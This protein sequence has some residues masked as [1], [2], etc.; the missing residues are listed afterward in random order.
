[1][2]KQLFLLTLSLALLASCSV[3][4]KHFKLEGRL[5]NLNQGELY[6]YSDE[7]GV[8]GIDTIKIGGGRFAYEIPCEK[9]ATIVLVF[10]NFSELPI[11]AEP[12]KTISIDGDASH[13]KELKVDGSK[14]NKLMSAFREQIASASPP[15]MSK[16]A[17]QQIEDHPDWPMG[18]YLVKKY[19]LTTPDPD[20]REA[21]RLIKTM[22]E[23][24][25]RNGDLVRLMDRITLL[26]GSALNSPIPTF[27]AYST[28]GRLVSSSDLM[29]GT[30]VIITWA[31]W[32]FDSMNMLRQVKQQL[33]GTGGRVKV[34]SISVDAS[35]TDCKNAIQ[36]DSLP[37]PNVCDEMM[38]ES[39]PVKQLALFSVPGN[40]VV[41]NGRI[42]ARNLST[43][44][45]KKKIEENL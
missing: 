9:P 2:F 15:E 42:I 44:D 17:R 12:G 27:T 29:S 16:Y 8:D 24:Q 26:Q 13:L 25:P 32:S 41:K 23:K 22:K 7:D 6:V 1:M 21:L 37:W 14:P 11:Y 31:S 45:L 36:R 19:F 35:K 39:K 28:N 43:E 30:A 18:T 4:S 3:D 20:Y 34:V 10:P 38:L 33:Q 5:L 40:L